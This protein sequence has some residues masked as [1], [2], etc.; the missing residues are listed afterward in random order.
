[1]ET[2]LQEGVF[3]IKYPYKDD[4]NYSFDFKQHREDCP[5]FSSPVQMRR[6]CRAIARERKVPFVHAT[7]ER[8]WAQTGG[9]EM[10][11]RAIVTI[12]AQKKCAPILSFLYAVSSNN[13]TGLYGTMG[14]FTNSGPTVV[15]CK[16]QGNDAMKTY[17]AWRKYLH[18]ECADI[19]KIPREMD[20]Y[21][22][23]CED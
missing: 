22:R 15:T 8:M 20:H 3:E 13:T 11:L 4:E 21:E 6:H 17:Y 12:P 10:H 7:V 5:S 19:L 23:E 2:Y 16:F 9:S 14:I 1:V 18:E